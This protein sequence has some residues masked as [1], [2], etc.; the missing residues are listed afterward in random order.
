MINK[1]CHF[2]KRD[3][4]LKKM[5]GLPYQ[6]KSEIVLSIDRFKGNDT[7]CKHNIQIKLVYI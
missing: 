3:T 5:A 6:L 7:K 2:F 1:T 4:R